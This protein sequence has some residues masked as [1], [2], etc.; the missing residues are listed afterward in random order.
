LIFLIAWWL[1]LLGGLFFL[2]VD[3]KKAE[4]EKHK[5]CLINSYN[6]PAAIN[7]AVTVL[8]LA[9]SSWVKAKNGVFEF[10]IPAKMD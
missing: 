3:S 2:I 6:T 7:N 9:A 10:T 5:I 8:S 4:K 1:L